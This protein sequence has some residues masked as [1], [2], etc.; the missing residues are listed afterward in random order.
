MQEEE[1][2]GKEKKSA[3]AQC[4]NKNVKMWLVNREGG[5]RLRRCPATAERELLHRPITAVQVRLPLRLLSFF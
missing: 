2:K 4:F 1:G 3:S 5:K